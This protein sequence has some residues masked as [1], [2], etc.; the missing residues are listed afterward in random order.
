MPVLLVVIAVL[1]IGGFFVYKETTRQV[2]WPYCPGMTDQDREEIKKSALDAQTV[3]W[4]TYENQKYGIEFKYP[5]THIV[6]DQSYVT[7]GGNVFSKLKIV[8]PTEEK[9]E[10]YITIGSRTSVSTA[11][12]ISCNSIFTRCKEFG[13][14]IIYTRSNNVF[15]LSLF[16]NVVNTAKF[17]K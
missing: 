11:P 14:N 5:S 12:D 15:I 4:K 13:S 17:T 6:L 8:S 16:D 9:D 3:N 7:P 2:C 1:V 10:Q